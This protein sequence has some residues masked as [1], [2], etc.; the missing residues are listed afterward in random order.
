MSTNEAAERL[1][2]LF[3]S[4]VMAAHRNQY[5]ADLDAALAHERSAG[6]APTHR[7]EADP[8]KVQVDG[9]SH[10]MCGRTIAEVGTVLD[11]HWLHVEGGRSAG[12]APADCYDAAIV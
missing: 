10:C 6:A 12:A 11:R 4:G 1:R 9:L 2:L 7:A 8:M 3:D 5:R